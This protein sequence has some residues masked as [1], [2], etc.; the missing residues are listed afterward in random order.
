MPDADTFG[1]VNERAERTAPDRKASAMIYRI[2]FP[3]DF[4][5][6]ISVGCALNANELLATDGRPVTGTAERDGFAWADVTDW[7]RAAQV[8][9]EIL[10]GTRVSVAPAPAPVCIISEW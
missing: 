10:P 3:V 2:T 1:T 7:Y 9:N 8:V 5:Q 6:L 4:L